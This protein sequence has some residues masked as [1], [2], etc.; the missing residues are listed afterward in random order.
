MF[1]KICNFDIGTWI[2]QN[3]GS[4][5][6]KKEKSSSGRILIFN[7][8]LLKWWCKFS[9]CHPVEAEGVGAKLL[10]IVSPSK[11]HFSLVS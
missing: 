8:R 4:S 1:F 5:Y 2:Q 7:L 9:Q 6:F 3:I 11:D 10:N